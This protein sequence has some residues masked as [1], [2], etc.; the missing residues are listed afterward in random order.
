[1]GFK[2]YWIKEAVWNPQGLVYSP[3][4]LLHISPLKLLHIAI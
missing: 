4:K 3:L 1:M 2:C